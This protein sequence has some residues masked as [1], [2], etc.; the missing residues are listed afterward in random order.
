MWDRSG[1]MGGGGEQH[2]YETWKE[3]IPDLINYESLG[4]MTGCSRAGEKWQKVMQ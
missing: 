2:H 4:V 1:W 3:P